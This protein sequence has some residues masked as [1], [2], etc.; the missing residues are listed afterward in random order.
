MEAKC[1]KGAR[2]DIMVDN[3]CGEENVA[4]WGS[5]YPVYSKSAGKIFKNKA[6]AFCNGVTDGIVWDVMMV[7]NVY[8][9]SFEGFKPLTHSI[10]NYESFLNGFD[11][12]NVCYVNFKPPVPYSTLN[13]LKCLQEPISICHDEDFSLPEDLTMSKEQVVQACSS[14]FASYY[15]M[16]GAFKNVFC[17]ICNNQLWNKVQSCMSL[18]TFPRVDTNAKFTTLLRKSYLEQKSNDRSIH[19]NPPLACMTTQDFKQVFFAI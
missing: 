8:M 19:N 2:K 1:P 6:C 7:C 15:S 14:S 11:P 13:H 12:D 18:Q 10:G 4:P 3:E 16:F 17:H 9:D 5:Y